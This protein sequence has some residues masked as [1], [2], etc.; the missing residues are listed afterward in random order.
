M[1]CDHPNG[2]GLDVGQF[3]RVTV[4]TRADVTDTVRN[5]MCVGNS[6]PAAASPSLPRPPLEG[7]PNTA[8]GC[9]SI[10]HSATT[11]QPDLA[12]TKVTSTSMGGDKAASARECSVTYTLVVSN[13]SVTPQAAT[14]IV[15]TVT[16][17]AFIAAQQHL[18]L[19]HRH[20]GQ[21]RDA[22]CD[23]GRAAQLFGRQCCTHV[24]R[25]GTREHHHIWR[26]HL[27]PGAAVLG[28]Q[29]HVRCGHGDPDLHLPAAC[30]HGQ[31][32]CGSWQ[33]GL[34]RQQEHLP[35][36]RSA[37]S[38]HTH[39][40]SPQQHRRRFGQRSRFPV[41]ERHRRRT[42]PHP[43]A[44]GPAH[45]QDRQRPFSVVQLKELVRKVQREK[46]QVKSIKR[47]GHATA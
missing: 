22:I 47:S 36:L 35:A 12:I 32:G 2:A 25:P 33:V 43:P 26:Q 15:I 46:L 30:R 7:D 19:R 23:T 27:Q 18:Q 39:R 37:R 13:V 17:P 9:R 28:E 44:G 14:R 42:E 24:H 45:H 38:A 41:G 5:T 11:V 6:V 40:H 31:H 16:V 21:R 34:R 1:V 3:L 10:G 4:V 20:V 8:N 29:C